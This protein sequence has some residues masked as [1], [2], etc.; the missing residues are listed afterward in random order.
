MATSPPGRD[1]MQPSADYQEKTPGE[2]G[3]ADGDQVDHNPASDML[4][5]SDPERTLPPARMEV[6]PPPDGGYGWICVLCVFLV[7]AHTWGINSVSSRGLETMI[8]SLTKSGNSH[9]VYSWLI[10]WTQMRFPGH[11]T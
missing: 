3:S 9:M 8:E 5:I 4:V 6:E 2:K 7:N 10:I 1:I 11:Q